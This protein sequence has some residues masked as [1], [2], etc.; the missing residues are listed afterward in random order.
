MKTFAIHTDMDV[1]YVEA[2]DR[3]EALGN[4]FEEYHACYSDD[5]VIEEVTLMEENL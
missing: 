2:E 5:I 4:Y 1:F 3:Y